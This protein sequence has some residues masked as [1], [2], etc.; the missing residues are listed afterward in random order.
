M[1]WVRIDIYIYIYI[2]INETQPEPYTTSIKGLIIKLELRDLTRLIK[3]VKLRF[4]YIYRLISI[5]A[6]AQPN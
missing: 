1:G 5:Y 4:T 2:Y 6:L 3:R